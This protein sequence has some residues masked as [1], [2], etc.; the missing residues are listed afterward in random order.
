[1]SSNVNAAHGDPSNE[2]GVNTKKIIA[3]GVVSLVIFAAS[4][5]VA[6]V[7]LRADEAQYAA[8]GVA[9]APQHLGVDE[10]GLVDQVAFDGDDRIERWQAD[11]RQRLNS[12]GWVDRQKGVIHIPIEEAMKEVVRQAGGGGGVK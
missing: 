6:G 10:V 8:R 3:V 11:R 5:V 1:M 4:A 9:A 2:D 12:Y 7:I